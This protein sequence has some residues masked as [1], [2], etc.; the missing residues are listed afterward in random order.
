[1]QT[2]ILVTKLT[3]EMVGHKDERRAAGRQWLKTVRELCPEVKWLHHYAILGR[4]DFLDIY[5]APDVETAH[6]V[7][8]I[9]RAQGAVEAE[10][11]QAL[12]YEQFVDLLGEVERATSG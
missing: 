2:Y 5:Q 3:S 11:W 7:S 4:Y 1:M 8:I 9:S 12:P 10:S 6:K